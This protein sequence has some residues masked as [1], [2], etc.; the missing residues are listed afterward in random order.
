MAWLLMK[1]A[2][3]QLRRMNVVEHAVDQMLSEE[4][5]ASPNREFDRIFGDELDYAA[6]RRW[7]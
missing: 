4:L 1:R 3:E 7:R 2:A 5:S 6:W